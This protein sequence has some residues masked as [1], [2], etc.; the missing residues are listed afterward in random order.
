VTALICTKY[1]VF[2]YKY[3]AHGTLRKTLGKDVVPSN[4]ALL[5][6]SPVDPLHLARP[7]TSVEVIDVKQQLKK[8][9]K[10]ALIDGLLDMQLKLEKETKLREVAPV[11]TAGTNRTRDWVKQQSRETSVHG[12]TKDNQKGSGSWSEDDGW[13]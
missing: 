8:V 10:D 12:N 11:E 9:P 6:T 2:R 5:A 3:R 7:V 4:A 1:A 13:N